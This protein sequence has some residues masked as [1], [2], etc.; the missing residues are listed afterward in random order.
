MAVEEKGVMSASGTR[1]LDLRIVFIKRMKTNIV[2]C[3]EYPSLPRRKRVGND[4]NK[5]TCARI[6]IWPG[7]TEAGGRGW[8]PFDGKREDGQR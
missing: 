1:E 3:A 4:G 7:W 8:S 5:T 2:G 6:A